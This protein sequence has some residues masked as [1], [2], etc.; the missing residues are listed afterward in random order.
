MQR[1]EEFDIIMPN[2]AGIFYAGEPVH[3]QVTVQLKSSMKLKG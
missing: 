3:G 2:T 1:L